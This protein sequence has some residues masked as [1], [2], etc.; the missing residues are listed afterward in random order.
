M[1]KMKERL[2]LLTATAL[3]ALGLLAGLHGVAVF[4]ENPSLVTMVRLDYLLWA[5]FLLSLAAALMNVKAFWRTHSVAS[6][7]TL[8]LA[9]A[10]L[11]ALARLA[12]TIQS[13]LDYD[14]MNPPVG[15]VHTPRA[16]PLALLIVPLSALNLVP[17]MAHLLLSQPIVLAE[18]PA[19]HNLLAAARP[20]L[21]GKLSPNTPRRAVTLAFLTA[22]LLRLYPELKYWPWHIGWDTVEYTAHL[23]DFLEKLN[24]FTAYHWMGAMRNI[25]PLLDILL[26]LPAKL[27]GAW[28][29][30]KAYPPLAYGALA[31]ATCIYAARL[32]G[33]WRKGYAASA[34]S[35]LYILNLRISWDYQRQHLGS[36]LL[37]AT[38]AAF[39]T[40]NPAPLAK[41]SLLVL[42][43]M[44]HEVT[45]FAAIALSAY[46]LW[47][48]LSRRRNP[49]APLLALAASTLLEIWYWKA[50][51]TPNPYTQLAPPGFVP[52]DYTDEAPQ[53][54]AYIAA[55]LAPILL[56]ASL[57]RHKPRYTAVTAL[58]LLLAGASPLIAPYTAAAT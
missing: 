54:L 30:F 55:G 48:T 47:E 40:A 6:T 44:S 11:L 49:A 26:A 51:V 20:L 16:F 46:W 39:D 53:A 50:P 4:R 57:T 42:T 34:L 12:S 38:L 35:S 31:A 8:N 45:A 36:I 24:P 32:S 14:L 9:Y 2:W 10:A 56:P 33:D 1:S 21:A 28:L 27:A 52:Y 13:M 41:A 3:N 17:S 43:A 37:V 25:P 29:T 5:D 15:T 7:Y 22:F 19:L 58:A 23:Q 18:A